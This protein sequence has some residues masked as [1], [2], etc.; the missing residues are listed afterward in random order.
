MWQDSFTI[1]N[2]TILELETYFSDKQVQRIIFSQFV[3]L[4]FC[5]KDFKS[6]Q[7]AAH[8]VIAVGAIYFH[9]YPLLFNVL[10]LTSLEIISY[11]IYKTWLFGY[12]LGLIFVNDQVL[13]IVTRFAFIAFRMRDTRVG[14]AAGYVFWKLVKT[15]PLVFN[16]LKLQRAVAAPRNLR[17]GN[18]GR[19]ARRN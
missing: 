6:W 4:K 18:N 19:F 9:L 2:S 10:V 1:Y 7:F 13:V 3:P 15:V 16:H 8:S 14:A 5:Y 11:Y 12:I 17:R